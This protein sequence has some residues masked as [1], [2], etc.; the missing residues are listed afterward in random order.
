MAKNHDQNSD[1]SRKGVRGGVAYRNLSDSY[2]NDKNYPRGLY[3]GVNAVLSLFALAILLGLLAVFTPLGDLWKGL[4]EEADIVY[5]LEFYDINGDL[6]AAPAEGTT[7]VDPQTGNALGE[8]V[9]IT[10]RPYVL[11]SSFL[12]TEGQGEGNSVLTTAKIVSVTV[13]LSARYEAGVGYTVH[14]MRIAKGL[15]YTVSFAGSVATGTCVSIE[16]R[17]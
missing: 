4:G 1:F 15:P 11:P 5:T 12:R 3:I 2:Q 7:L 8:I 10:S 17:W 16:K 14:G 9:A 13:A 6:S